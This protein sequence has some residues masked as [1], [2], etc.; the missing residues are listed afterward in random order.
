MTANFKFPHD[1]Y[2]WGQD[3]LGS[4][5]PLLSHII[6]KL[7]GLNAAWSVSI[8]NYLILIA[9]YLCISIL[10]R[11][12]SI[13]LILAVFWFFPPV[14]FLD[15]LM[16]A[17]PFGVQMSLLAVAIFIFNKINYSQSAFK[18]VMLISLISI[19]LIVSMWVSD[20]TI[21]SI[22]LLIALAL[23]NYFRDYANRL[24]F[25]FKMRNIFKEPALYITL[26]WMFAGYIFIKY[27]KSHADQDIRYTKQMF[28]DL[29][30]VFLTIKAI[31]F[32]I[33]DILTFNY[34]SNI[35][36]GLFG[37]LSVIALFAITYF[38]IKMRGKITSNKWFWFFMT[39]AILAILAILVSYWVFRNGVSRRYFV[40]AYISLVLAILLIS[41]KFPGK[42]KF[43]INILLILTTIT[44]LLSSTVHIYYPE[45][46]KSKYENMKE[47]RRLGKAGII[48]EY[49]NSYI[50]AIA[51]PNKITVTPNDRSYIRNIKMAD[52]VFRQPDIYII[53]DLWLD[54]FPENISQYGYNLQKA[55]KPFE[56]GGATLCE[57]K[58]V[59]V[60]K[61]YTSKE[62]RSASKK[63]ITDNNSQS[64]LVIE[65]DSSSRYRYL[66]YGPFIDLN[67]GKYRIT[68]NLRSSINTD[69]KKIAFLDATSGYGKM[70]L[71]K[72]EIK[73]TDFS[74]TINYHPFEI[75]FEIDS[76]KKNI[77]FRVYYVGK[78]KLRFDSLELL[79]IE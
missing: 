69:S 21:I 45:R 29:D 17:Q 26:F 32:Q 57:Y 30:T 41:D 62:L 8:T 65:V 7:T 55:H 20:L 22:F 28:N 47:F 76:L 51:A 40:L 23:F 74:D 14:N 53:K 39:Q 31:S 4:F 78:D 52:S 70:V 18:R 2:F 71:A 33:I 66:V 61:L 16:I 48:S 3:R 15:F 12:W 73:Q 19:T 43:G 58:V 77:E 72:R 59:K 44:G 46:Q 27:A 50:T 10:F 9:G 54:S 6:V 63:I 36:L 75:A 68:F 34:E 49:W 13:K 11:S 56:L 35:F 25:R 60:H 5:V 64:R 67:K 42:Q 38:A 24:Q 79:Q 37:W 1:L